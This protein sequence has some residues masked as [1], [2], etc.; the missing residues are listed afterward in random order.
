MVF[1]PC[2]VKR[3][4]LGGDCHFKFTVSVLRGEWADGNLCGGMIIYILKSVKVDFAEKHLT[5]DAC[6]NKDMSGVIVIKD[7]TEQFGLGWSTQDTMALEPQ[8]LQD[9]VLAH[10]GESGRGKKKDA[11]EPARRWQ[12]AE[13]ELE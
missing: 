12:I 13:V 8:F 4:S 7:E 1:M 2:H 9:H 5:G 10:T 3:L 6:C 11:A